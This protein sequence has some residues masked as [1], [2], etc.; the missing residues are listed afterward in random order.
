MYPSL[1]YYIMLI[2]QIQLV[3]MY[4]RAIKTILNKLLFR[5]KT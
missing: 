1:K 2:I 4:Q 3:E 5:L